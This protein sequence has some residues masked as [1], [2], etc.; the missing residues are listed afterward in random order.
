VRGVGNPKNLESRRLYSGEGQ[1]GKEQV[2][3]GTNWW[4]PE[5]WEQS[6]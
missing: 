5:E 4:M 6:Q 2:Q 3:G 1:A